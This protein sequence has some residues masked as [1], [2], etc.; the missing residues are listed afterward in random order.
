MADEN[1]NELG[2]DG[3]PT[4]VGNT[5]QRIA[6]AAVA[7]TFNKEVAEDIKA[8]VSIDQVKDVG[9]N[10]EQMSVILGQNPPK[11]NSVG[12]QNVKTQA[13]GTS[14]PPEKA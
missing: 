4:P 5:A 14:N 1:K 13:E 3:E 10:T 7:A 8:N 2:P 9:L 12:L 6:G 11:A